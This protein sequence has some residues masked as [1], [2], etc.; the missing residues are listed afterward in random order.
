MPTSGTLVAM[1]ASTDLPKQFRVDKPLVRATGPDVVL[2]GSRTHLGLFTGGAWLVLGWHEIE[3]GS[4][5][6]ET[7]TFKWLDLSGTAQ[8]VRL[9]A[10]GRMPEL[11]QERMQASTVFTFHYDLDH[12]AVSIVGRRSLADGT[13]RCYAVPSGG[14]DL[15][16]PATARF[17][18]AET[19]R[20][21]SEYGLDWRL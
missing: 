10:A 15:T 17:V 21:R 3:R 11:F 14:A 16:D 2:V 18:V 20:L 19:D 9:D 12:G 13:V 4:W 1:T 8:T 6:G 5:N 7:K